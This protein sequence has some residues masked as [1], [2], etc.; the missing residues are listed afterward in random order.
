MP[1]DTL[2]DILMTA[3]AA[4]HGAIQAYGPLW[5]TLFM[6]GL[7][8]SATHCVG[9]CGPFVVS[10]TVARLEGVPAARMS[11]FQRLTGAAL[12]PY[13]LGRLTT[14]AVLGAIAGGLADTAMR[15]T[16]YT[17]LSSG[18]LLIAA[19]I[20]A[21]Y[22][23]GRLTGWSAGGKASG[24]SPFAETIGRVARPLFARPTGMRGYGLG[25]ALGFLPCGLL[26]AAL[27]AAAASGG[28]FAGGAAMAAFA[29]GTIPALFAVGF[30]SRVAGQ[31]WR[32][33]ATRALPVILL[34]N[35]ATLSYM[36]VRMIA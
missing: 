33:L 16:G 3:I 31:Q 13:H 34:I 25:V 21:G 11:E 20:F 36:A 9:M 1:T 19:A 4:C 12:A 30:A 26:Y 28:A 35:A 29:L 24:A 14:Y 5:L 8:G 17:W 15:L 23:L 2:N 32:G 22:A 6:A 18:L 27:S 10:Q 7:L